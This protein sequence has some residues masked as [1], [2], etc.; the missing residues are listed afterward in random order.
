MFFV[1]SRAWGKEKIL[2]SREELKIFFLFHAPDTLLTLNPNPNPKQ[3]PSSKTLFHLILH[4]CFFTFQQ[5]QNIALVAVQ[6][7]L[8]LVSLFCALVEKASLL[9]GT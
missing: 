5:E 2:S 4:C 1:L 8:P 7:F 9:T 6:N 3:L